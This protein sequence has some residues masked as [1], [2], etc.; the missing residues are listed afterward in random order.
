[1]ARRRPRFR[2]DKQN[3]NSSKAGQRRDNKQRIFPYSAFAGRLRHH[4]RGSDGPRPPGGDSVRPGYIGCDRRAIG[5]CNIC[6]LGRIGRYRRSVVRFFR[7]SPCGCCR[8]AVDCCVRARVCLRAQSRIAPGVQG[9]DR[10]GRGY[11]AAQY[12]RSDFRRPFRRKSAHEP[13]ALFWPLANFRR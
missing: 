11:I 7:A 4:E 9:A 2:G 10:F 13:S 1:M 8:V 12:G 5:Y 6:G 3:R